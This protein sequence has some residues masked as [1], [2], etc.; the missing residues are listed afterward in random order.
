[1][2][3]KLAKHH[4]LW[5]QMLINLGCDSNLAKDIV[6]DMAIIFC[7][8]ALYKI[9][10]ENVDIINLFLHEHFDI[11]LNDR[12]YLSTIKNITSN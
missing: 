7:A 3:E 1:M 2:L 4:V 10:N 9:N 5:L 11:K 6:Q 12:D 8:L